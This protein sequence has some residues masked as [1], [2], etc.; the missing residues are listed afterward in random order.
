[1][2]QYNQ[3]TTLNFR[4][5]PVL[6]AS[7]F[8]GTASA[9]GFQL[10]E[11]NASGLGN[12]FAGS[13]AVAEDA[14]TVFWNPA[15]M[16]LLPG[17]QFVVG[18]DAVRPSA[19]FSNSGSV[20]ATGRPLGSNGGDAGDWGGVPFGYFTMQIA[21]SLTFGLGLSAPFGLKTEYDSDWAGRFLAVKSEIKTININ[22][23][24]AWKV[25][26]QV[27]L[28]FGVNWQ[29]V[30][31]ELTRKVNA[32]AAEPLA[33]IEADDDA[34]GYNLGAIFQ[35]SPTTRIGASYRSEIKYDLTGNATFEA[36]ASALNTP[37][38]ADIKLPDVFILSAVQQLGDKWEMLGDISWTGWSKL[39]KLTIKRAS[40]TTLTEENL[41]WRDTFRVAFGANYKYSDQWKIRMGIAFD[42]SPVEDQFRL[43][44]VPDNDRTWLSIGAQYKPSKESAIDFGYTYIFIKDAP[45]N[46]NGGV[47]T[48][49]TNGTLRGDYDSNVHILGVQYAQSF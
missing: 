41:Q 19:K 23:S 48:I 9:A 13:A 40:G 17:K 33:K 37:I 49:P 30:D 10:L 47:T 15:G 42:Q 2:K 29:R 12:A 8:S 22:P 21:P 43:P 5:L 44:R 34:W 38:K 39:E 3:K 35:V 4:A 25:N 6:V 46:A 36:P 11:Q 7:L 14:S 20:A 31:A 1:M 32:V 16:A 24:I 28:G 26:D 18:V 27:S 45:I